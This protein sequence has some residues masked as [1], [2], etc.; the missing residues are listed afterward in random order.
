MNRKQFDQNIAA[1]LRT[2]RE[3]ERRDW[4]AILLASANPVDEG[5]E[6]M[7]LV[8]IAAGYQQFVREFPNVN[9]DTKTKQ[10]AYA[11]LRAAF[12]NQH[13]PPRQ[14]VSKAQFGRLLDMHLK[15][16]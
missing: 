15:L 13:F 1:A 11:I 6:A 2:L 9:Y 16:L 8:K 14:H 7:K 12:E 10:E 5:G 4:H 3:V